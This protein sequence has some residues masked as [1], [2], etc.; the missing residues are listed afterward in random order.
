METSGDG[1]EIDQTLLAFRW[2]LMNM[3][4][5][6]MVP[7]SPLCLLTALSLLTPSLPALQ[8]TRF[9][10]AR[11]EIQQEYM[12]DDSATIAGTL[13]VKEEVLPTMMEAVRVR[14]RV[15]VNA[16]SA[17]PENYLHYHV[18]IILK[19]SAALYPEPMPWKTVMGGV[20]QA[21]PMFDYRCFGWYSASRV[22]GEIVQFYAE[23]SYNRKKVCLIAIIPSI[24]HEKSLEMVLT[25]LCDGDEPYTDMGLNLAR[26]RLIF[27]LMTL[28]HHTANVFSELARIPEISPLIHVS[29]NQ[30]PLDI[31]S[32]YA[33]YTLEFKRQKDAK[34]ERTDGEAQTED[35]S[36]FTT[37]TFDRPFILCISNEENQV[38]FATAIRRMN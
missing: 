8:R 10:S 18:H 29:T 38:L 27:P 15:F 17:A 23:S 3:D 20:G 14:D 9:L 31:S 19:F 32:C 2:L 11:Q 26:L 5:R 13:S 34:N 16:S 12:F 30:P 25:Q 24:Q 7:T 37:V 1:N 35:L 4:S 33:G 6:A 28:S 36:A 21:V 22:Y